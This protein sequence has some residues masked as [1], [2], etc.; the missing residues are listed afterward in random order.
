MLLPFAF[1]TNVKKDT[2]T[3]KITF[4]VISTSVRLMS[5][6]TC[7]VST[8]QDPMSVQAVRLDILAPSQV[9]VP[10]TALI[11]MN[12]IMST[13]VP[14]GL[15]STPME[16]FTVNVPLVMRMLPKRVLSILK[17]TWSTMDATDL[18]LVQ[19]LMSAS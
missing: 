6:V 12:V 14:M 18:L 9:Q 7:F 13:I 4:V 2:Q 17:T 16:A 3:M 11:L 10:P 19:T 1:L 5:V 15:A 8:H